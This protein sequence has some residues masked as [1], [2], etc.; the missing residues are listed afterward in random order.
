MGIRL[1]FPAMNRA[2]QASGR[3]IRSEE[4]RGVVLFLDE[5]YLWS[6][7]RKVFPPDM[8]L[9]QTKAPWQEIAEFYKN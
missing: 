6:N 5:R 3:C 1:L 4:D 2:I 7:Y 8:S 9:K